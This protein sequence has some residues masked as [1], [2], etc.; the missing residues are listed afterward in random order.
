M[1]RAGKQN[2][3]SGS[4]DVS[5][6]GAWRHA[7]TDVEGVSRLTQNSQTKNMETNQLA[8]DNG[9]PAE[10]TTVIPPGRDGQR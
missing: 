2:Y 4:G 7:G 3:I 1:L 10:Q 9:V 5:V 6:P 8:G